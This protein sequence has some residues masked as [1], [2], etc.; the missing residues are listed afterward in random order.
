MN[1][2]RLF[3]PLFFTLA[4]LSAC[5]RT[6]SSDIEPWQPSVGAATLVAGQG[7]TG[8][9]FVAARPRAAASDP[10]YTP[11][12]DSPHPIP[13]LRSG[14]DEHT[15]QPGDTLGQIAQRY[16][17]SVAEIAE[18]NQMADINVLA[19]GQ[20][21]VIPEPAPTVTG[22]NFKIIPDSELVAS[23]MTANFDV[24]EFIQAQNGYLSRHREEVGGQT[25]WGFQ[26]VKLVARDYSLNPRILLAVLEYQGDWVTNPN[27]RTE[28]MKYPLDWRDPNR[29]G[30]Y[31]QLSWAANMLNRGF[32]WWRSN[33]VATWFLTDN[34]V[35]PI[36]PTINAGTAAVQ[37]LF[38]HFY[39]Y[40]TWERTVT[41]EGLFSIYED[42]FGYPFDYS[43][44][45][46]VPEGIAQ[47]EMLL[48]FER[49]VAWAFTGGPHGGWADGAAWGALDFAPFVE[50]RGC[51]TSD[52]WVVAVADGL[53]VRSEDGAVVQDLDSDGKEQTGWT[54]LYMHIES[55]DRVPE[56]TF[57]KAGERVGHPSCEGGFTN[58]THTHI[59][60]RYNGEWLDA[61]HPTPFVLDGWVA[62]GTDNEY[63]GYLEKGDDKIEAFDGTAEWNLIQR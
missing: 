23:P 11:T 48:P 3:I 21:L 19:I 34:A 39:G 42:L 35:V 24:A 26:I 61:E 2:K 4:T 28:S 5:V 15:V 45:P 25:L 63:D 60:R 40:Q 50:E 46:V 32:Y 29:E 49:G 52:E 44:E 55:R 13:G 1:L 16:N 30:L 54:V 22:P 31:L 20:V 41:G 38:S 14:E 51:F 18:A 53:I 27:P 47:P 7:T 43:Y 33:Q 36:D 12:P 17:V 59:A 58:G 56:G 8:D 62:I 37:Y 57:L 6:T 10:R 9:T